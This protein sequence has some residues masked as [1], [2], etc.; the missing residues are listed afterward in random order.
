[1]GS[2]AVVMPLDI[3]F[4]DV[5]YTKAVEDAVVRQADRLDNAC[6]QIVRCRVSLIRSQK[7]CPHGPSVSV[8]LDLMTGRQQHISSSTSNEDVHAAL[9]DAFT[10]LANELKSPNYIGR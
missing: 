7:Y 2:S 6:A 9:Q 8:R 3:S 4:Q 1:M 10:Q 5:P